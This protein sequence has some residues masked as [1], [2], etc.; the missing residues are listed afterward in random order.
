MGRKIR[1]IV[2]KKML[3]DQVIDLFLKSPSGGLNYKQIAAKLDIKDGGLKQLITTILYELK[4][5]GILEEEYAGNFKYKHKGAYVTGT[6]DMTTSGSAYILTD[7]MLE[8]IFISREH[9]LNALH[10]DT[11]KV[12]VFARKRSRKAEGEIIEIIKRARATFVGTIDKVNNFAFLIPDHKNMPFDIF[13]PAEQLS[14]AKNGDRAIVKIVSWSKG[15]KNPVG[16]IVEILGKTGDHHAEMHAILAEF[17]LPIRFPEEI[18]RAAESLDE[19]ITQEEIARRRDFRDILTFT[20]DPEDAKDFDDALSFRRLENGNYEI[21]IHIAD[22]THYIQENSLLEKE[23]AERATSVYLVDRVVPMLPE[24]LSN[25]ICSLRPH[26][27]KLCFSAVVEM[28][29]QAQVINRWFGRTIIHSNQRFSYQD[30]QEIIDKKEGILADE[31]AILNR[32]AQTMRQ[33]R[34]KQGAIAFDRIELK[35]KLDENGKPLGVY[36]RLHG[37]ANELIEE[38]ML[39]ANRLVAEFIGKTERGRQAKTFVYRIHDKPDP[40]KLMNLA[41]FIQRFG[42]TINPGKGESTSHALNRLLDQVEGK[43][44]QNIIETLAVRTMAK[45]VYS[46]SNIGHYGLSFAHYTHFTSPIRRYPDMMVHR[47][48]AAYLNQEKSKDLEN[49]ESLCKHSSF[50]E[51]QAAMAE[52]A[53]V[54]YKAVEFMQ[55][56][57]GQI[58]SGIISGVTE[59]GIYVEMIENKIEGMIPIRDL[60]DDFYVFDDSEYCLSG[61][62]HG[63]QYRLGD[64]INVKIVRTN[65]VK[66]QLDLSISEQD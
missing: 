14:K 46:T 36:Q 35:F 62:N 65:L 30:A 50:M 54:K 39:L 24:R 16:E 44:E 42:Y 63:K 53:S 45:A 7:E 33:N 47:L 58:F 38:F 23:A 49:Y 2:T 25:F 60:D 26:E 8:D 28:N 66:K 57:I 43:A 15:T 29:D 52:R 32:L 34:F 59:W 51:Q 3:S 1:K 48:L 27:D 41:T 10:G 37:T 4:A 31:L 56:K 40:E 13:I 21:G 5:T 19:K 64:Q 18:N 12:Y 9:M 6:V 17:G 61:Q 11:V 22:V 20:I 55:D